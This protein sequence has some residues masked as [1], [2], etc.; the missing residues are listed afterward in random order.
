MKTA[1]FIIFLSIQLTSFGQSENFSV[2][3]AALEGD[4]NKDN[5]EDKVVVEQDTL[6]NEF[7]FRIQIFFAEPNGRFKLITSSTALI[8]AQYPN[9]KGNYKEPG[10]FHDITLKNGVICLNYQ[11]L[12]GYFEHK[13]RYQN[14]NFELIGFTRIDETVEKQTTKDFNLST[15]KYIETTLPAGSDKPTVKKKRMRIRPL[16]KLQDIETI[17]DYLY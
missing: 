4:L 7:P 13:F 1:F 14:G 3:I 8:E 6:N 9:G 17:T 5:L 10:G 12:R 15:G 11:T 16:P 2:P